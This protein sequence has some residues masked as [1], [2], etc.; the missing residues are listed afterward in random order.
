MSDFEETADMLRNLPLSYIHVF[1]FSARAGTDAAKMSGPIDDLIVKSRLNILAEINRLKR[2]AYMER[3]IDIPMDIILEEQVATGV[4][5]GTSGNYLKVRASVG[6]LRKRKRC[7]CKAR[8][9]I[10]RPARCGCYGLAVTGRNSAIICLPNTYTR[11]IA[12]I[13]LHRNLNYSH[14]YQQDV[15]NW[16]L[17]N[18]SDKIYYVKSSQKQFNKLIASWRLLI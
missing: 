18:L 11:P 15:N 8:E 2:R 13:P 6:E 16:C 3:Q 9:D 10:G 7:V 17:Y 1:P 12:A 5:T 14:E 4:Y